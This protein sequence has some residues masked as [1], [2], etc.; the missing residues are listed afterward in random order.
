MSVRPNPARWCVLL[1][2]GGCSQQSLGKFNTPPNVSIMNPVDG[3]GVDLGSAVEFYGRAVDDQDDG[4]LLTVQWISSID[5]DLGGDPPDIN[6]DAFFATNA[7]SAGEHVITLKAVDTA[8]ESAQTTITLTVGGDGSRIGQGSPPTVLLTGPSTDDGP[9]VSG[10]TITFVGVATDPDQDDSTLG[11]TMVSQ[12]DGLVWEGVPAADGRVDFDLDGLTVGTHTLVLKALDDD[13]NEGE[14]ILDVE[15]LEDGRPRVEIISPASGETVWTTD[16][17]RFEA[18]ISDRETDVELLEITWESSLDG[19]LYEGTPDS[20][21]ASLV[22]APLTEGVHTITLSAL[23]EDDKVGSESVVVEAV[24][25]L[26]HDGDL[27]GYTENEG[28][29][30]DGESAINPG[31]SESCDALDNDCDG[32][33]NED[34]WDTYEPNE[35]GATAY[36]LGEVDGSVIWAGGTVT[37]AGLTMHE[38]LDEDWITLDADDD[39]YDNVNLGITVTGLPAAGAYAVEL[40]LYTGSGWTVKTST[41]G[42]GSLYIGYVGDVWDDDEDIWAVRVYSTSWPPQCAAPY[43]IRID[44]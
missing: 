44:A 21:G 42:S 20:T 3:E 31:R 8:G 28:D 37:L 34:W 22:N 26:N 27:D 38:E 29:C 32:D 39:W 25:P 7:L 12:R 13:G 41:A 23:D 6:G 43:T 5:L 40:L 30:D 9:W 33:V 18:E 11:V 36:D 15:I 24:D 1:L 16:T 2:A 35:T 10:E 4:D 17:V 14:D 19:V